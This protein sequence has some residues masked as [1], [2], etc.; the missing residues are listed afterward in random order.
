[1]PTGLTA[2]RQTG[3]QVERAVGRDFDFDFCLD[4]DLDLDLDT[5]ASTAA[6][7][8]TLAGNR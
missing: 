2:T 8:T 4:L 1:M 7:D 3:V 6:D 5:K